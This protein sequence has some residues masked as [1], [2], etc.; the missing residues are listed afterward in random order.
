MTERS[1]LTDESLD[2]DVIDIAFNLFCIYE[3]M[4]AFIES[5]CQ[6]ELEYRS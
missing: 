4:S 2:H 3:Q 6:H 5:A 1:L